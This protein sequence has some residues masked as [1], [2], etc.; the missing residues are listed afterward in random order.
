MRRIDSPRRRLPLEQKADEALDKIS[1]MV[2]SLMRTT[3]RRMSEW[4]SDTSNKQR[5]P[6]IFK[7]QVL[8]INRVESATELKENIVMLTAARA[9][10]IGLEEYAEV[11]TDNRMSLCKV[12]RAR[13]KDR[14]ADGCIRMNAKA[15]TDLQVAI[16]DNVQVLP[17]FNS[18]VFNETSEYLPDSRMV[19]VAV[20]PRSHGRATL[21]QP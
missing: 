18:D 6:N 7:V 9:A 12:K 20:G 17:I 16:G 5:P 2:G 13:L 8:S 1:D 15:R 14:L 10:E 19:R 3:K 21:V 4:G 11:R